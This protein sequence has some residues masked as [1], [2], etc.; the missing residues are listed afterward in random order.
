M[1]K[2]VDDFFSKPR[3]EQSPW[4]LPDDK[5][6]AVMDDP[7][8]IP[9][10]VKGKD[11]E[12]MVQGTKDPSPEKEPET[13]T[14][15]E[16][17]TTAEKKPVIKV[18]EVVESKGEKVKK[19]IPPRVKG[20]DVEKMV[21]GKTPSVKD[22]IIDAAITKGKISKK[23]EEDEGEK[24]IDE[25]LAD[26]AKEKIEEKVDPIGKAE[27]II[28]KKAE[29]AKE[30][31][32]DSIISGDDEAFRAEQ[33]AKKAAADAAAGKP[34]ST[35]P[36][37][38]ATAPV[39]PT[40]AGSS[41]SAPT[42]ASKGTTASTKLTDAAGKTPTTTPKAVKA[43]ADD[44][45]GDIFKMAPGKAVKTVGSDIVA[46]SRSVA[47]GF[48]DSKNLRLAATAALLSATGFGIG[49]V[50]NRSSKPNPQLAGPDE[51]E[52]IRRQMLEDG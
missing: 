52:M 47:R 33:A 43:L 46:M 10:R 29:K 23:D 32:I 30:D 7:R 39:T 18:G 41:P 26:K 45:A 19:D 5:K 12:K 24:D 37:S 44:A 8:Y 20:K 38:P 6:K 48:K 17:T 34:I 21:E 25:K 13:K 31:L 35:P 14:V 40:P 50:R 42:P 2:F 9:P 22:E 49:K 1:K 11:V 15:S 51:S 36:S 4:D 16:A 3:A 27:S 28:E